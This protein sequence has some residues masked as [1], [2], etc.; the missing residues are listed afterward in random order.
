LAALSENQLRI[1]SKIINLEYGDYTPPKIFYVGDKLY[2]TTTDLQS[3]KLYVYDSQGKLLPKFPIYASKNAVVENIDK[4]GKPEI[5]TLSDDQTV[6]VYK[7][8]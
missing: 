6:L 5:I 7:M 4:R 3:K 8:N 1:N 2:I